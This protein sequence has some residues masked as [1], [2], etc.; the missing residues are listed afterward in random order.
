M[1]SI[2]SLWPALSFWYFLH[3][4]FPPSVYLSLFYIIAWSFLCRSYCQWI[5]PIL[6]SFFLGH[7]SSSP[8]CSFISK[9]PFHWSQRLE[10]PF[11][12]YGTWPV[13]SLPQAAGLKISSFFLLQSFSSVWLFLD[14]R[15][16]CQIVSSCVKA[17]D[18]NWAAEKKRKDH[19]SLLAWCPDLHNQM[20]IQVQKA[21]PPVTDLAASE[22]GVAFILTSYTPCYSTITPTLT[23][24][25][26]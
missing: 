2:T 18:M 21:D 15:Y 26:Y 1:F 17:S 22:Q 12:L 8:S 14:K 10:P 13:D 5:P 6:S 7:L 25:R 23:P 3:R 20:C 9:L 11:I 16:K 19:C 4:S 24:G